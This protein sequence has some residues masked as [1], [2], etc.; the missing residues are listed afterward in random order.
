[1]KKEQ[2]N[3]HNKRQ[4]TK[5]N[6]II[7]ICRIGEIKN[8]FADIYI[9][10]ASNSIETIQLTISTHKV[11]TNRNIVLNIFNAIMKENFLECIFGNF[12]V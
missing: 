6:I 8:T 3:M 2:N 1:M 5:K 9:S 7:A 11:I 4:N 10:K 12:F